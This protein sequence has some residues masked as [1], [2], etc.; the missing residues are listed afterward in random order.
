MRYNLVTHNHK[1]PSMTMGALN[2]ILHQSTYCE[3]IVNAIE[4]CNKLENNFYGESSVYAI[5]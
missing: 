5:E 4:L 3:V 2:I 1:V